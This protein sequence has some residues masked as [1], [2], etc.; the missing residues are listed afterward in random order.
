MIQERRSIVIPISML[1]FATLIH[2]TAVS[3]LPLGFQ[4]PAKAHVKTNDANT[5][6]MEMRALAAGCRR[7]N[8]AMTPA[9]ASG[10]SRINQARASFPI[11]ALKL[12]RGQIFHVRGLTF[13]IQRD[14]QR[15]A[16]SNFRR[17]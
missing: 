3:T 7:V 8:S 12:H 9:A 11:R 6:Q 16:D 14:D 1:K 15:E 4:A 2:C 10:K 5:A 13:A 17:G